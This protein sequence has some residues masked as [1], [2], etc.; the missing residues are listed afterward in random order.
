VDDER[1][2]REQPD[3]FSVPFRKSFITP[4]APSVACDCRF[5]SQSRFSALARKLFMV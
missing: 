5:A 1:M 3:P 2:G 4:K